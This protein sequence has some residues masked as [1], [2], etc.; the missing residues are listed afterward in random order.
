MQQN[1]SQDPSTTEYQ[2]N[3]WDA[4]KKSINGLVNKVNIPNIQHIVLELFNE[5]V[6]RGKGLLCRSIQKA[7]MASQTF[8]HVFAA[9]IAIINTKLPQ[10]GDLL[11]RR[12]V[13]QFQR[14]FK[15]NDKTQL[16]GLCKFIGHLANQRVAHEVIVLQILMLL[17]SKPT[18]DSVEVAI[19]FLREVGQFLQEVSPRGLEAVFDTLRNVLHQANVDTRVQYMIE[20]IMAVRKDKFSE[21]PQVIKALDL[22]EE[23]DQITHQLSLD[24]KANEEKLLDVFKFDSKYEQN[25]ASYK[26]LRAEIL[27]EGSDEDGSEESGSEEDSSE[28]EEVPVQATHSDGKV[29][30]KDMTDTQVKILRRTIYLTI[31][32]SASFEECAHKLLKG[33]LQPG[34]EKELANMI[35]ECCQQERTYLKF[36]G[37][38]ARR[39]CDLQREYQDAFCLEFVEQ[40]NMVH[41]LETNKLR[42]MAKLFAHLFYTDAIPWQVLEMIHL[43]EL[44]TTSSSRIFIKELMMEISEFMGIEGMNKKFADPYMQ[45][46]FTGLFPRDIPKNTRFAINFFTSIGLG[47]LTED[48]RA[49]HAAAPKR[50][51]AQQQA[52][53]ESDSESGSG[54]SSSG[55]SSSNSGSGSSSDNGSSSSSGSGSSSGSSSSGS[56]SG[57]NSSSSSSG[58]SSDDGKSRKKSRRKKSSSPRAEKKKGKKESKEKAP[59]PVATREQRG[60]D[61]TTGDEAFAGR[62]RLSRGESDGG[63]KG[64]GGGGR[65]E[66]RDRDGRRDDRDRGRDRRDDDR[67]REDSRRRRRS[68]SPDDRERSK[69]QRD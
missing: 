9:L 22:V 8:T 27:G 1:M 40:Y 63:S 35:I 28:E 10:T 39:F 44:E 48:L 13:A 14:S 23:D 11:L 66:D 59:P 46:A 47:G 16:I 50:I 65:R 61:T 26:E 15:R 41:Q 68:Q 17:L 29:V 25:E 55:S 43:N 3:A 60:G 20:V 31:K 54:S 21:H 34:M 52:G 18:N 36:F 51:M 37:L 24:G 69:R 57:S 53:L 6:I 64:G 2:R 19:T 32:S 45:A 38:L 7:Q 62:A 12:L 49:Y 5:N 33:T 56:S 67:G 42:Q 4:L 30:I 58:S